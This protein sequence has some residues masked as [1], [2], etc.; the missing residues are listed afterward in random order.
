MAQ[1]AE[2]TVFLRERE[3]SHYAVEA[4]R[5]LRTRLM[6]LQ[7]SKG[8]RSIALSSA[9]P[10][11]GKTVTTLNLGLCYA[12]LPDTRVLLIDGD[13]RSR[14]LTQCLGEPSAP[15]LAEVL[16]GEAHYDDAILATDNPNLHVLPAGN[17]PVGA[18]ELLAGTAWKEL[19]ASCRESFK[20][21]LVDTPPVTP[22]ADFEL[23]SAGCDG[24]VMVV[25]AHQAQRDVL[26]QAAG[27]ID[28]KKLLGV[29]LNST[30]AY[31]RSSYYEQYGAPS[32]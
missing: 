18:P 1:V 15:G 4:F 19:I 25:R 30:D 32:K 14:R 16:S 31:S 13:L 5:A 11:E 29:I 8:L 10:G 20:L 17:S 12:Q 7:A 23:I 21:I 28:K 22:L 3:S 24:F 27:Q 26:Q 9:T 2:S 6:R